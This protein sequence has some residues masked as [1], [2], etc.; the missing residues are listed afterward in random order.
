MQ[1]LEID[2]FDFTDIFAWTFLNFLARYENHKIS[3]NI[4]HFLSKT[5]S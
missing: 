2:L 5:N 1:F 3:N 4:E